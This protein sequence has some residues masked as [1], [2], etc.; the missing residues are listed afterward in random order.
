M[1]TNGKSTTVSTAL[2]N[3]FITKYAPVDHTVAKLCRAKFCSMVQRGS[4]IGEI[5]DIAQQEGWYFWLKDQSLAKLLREVRKYQKQELKQNLK[6]KPPRQYVRLNSRILAA[7]QDGKIFSIDSLLERLTKKGRTTPKKSKIA[8]WLRV[9]SI[10]NPNQQYHGYVKHV[11][12]T[13]WQATA[14]CSR[15][16]S[17]TLLATAAVLSPG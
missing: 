2:W 11:S 6:D 7:I 17:S 9:H 16:D 5:A 13:T 3:I 4:A 12:A 10:E 8:N 1:S 14:T 15:G